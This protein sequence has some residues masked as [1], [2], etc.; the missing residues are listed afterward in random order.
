MSNWQPDS[1]F[2]VVVVHGTQDIS[3]TTWPNAAEAKHYM[4][5]LRQQ[6]VPAAS[7][8]LYRARLVKPTLAS[9]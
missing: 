8:R 9:S 4:R 5:R 3:R 7:I 6:G 2:V 1:A